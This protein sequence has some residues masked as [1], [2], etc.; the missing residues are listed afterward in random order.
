MQEIF[1][2]PKK[3][4]ILRRTWSL[5]KLESIIKLFTCTLQ[6]ACALRKPS[7]E[8]RIKSENMFEYPFDSYEEYI[9]NFANQLM[10]PF[11][12][13]FG[14]LYAASLLGSRALE[15]D[16]LSQAVYDLEEQ[17]L[18]RSLYQDDVAKHAESEA[19]KIV[20]YLRCKSKIT[21]CKRKLRLN[22]V[23]MCTLEVIGMANKWRRN[24]LNCEWNKSYRLCFIDEIKAQ[25]ETIN[26]WEVSIKKMCQE[27]ATLLES[28]KKVEKSNK[29]S[30]LGFAESLNRTYIREKISEL[31]K[32]AVENYNEILAYETVFAKLN[33]KFTQNYSDPLIECQCGELELNEYE[34]V[35]YTLVYFICLEF[36]EISIF[37]QRNISYWSILIHQ[38]LIETS[39]WN[40]RKGSVLCLTS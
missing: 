11:I 14:I 2:N 27:L 13:Y 29:S 18:E 24:E 9:T 23:K 40:V 28:V 34:K 7:Q 20:D 15:N 17:A 12:N 5:R 21:V 3:R 16:S 6:I 19:C 4:E 35:S 38:I 30:N 31:V 10:K 8:D 25:L 32:I 36:L 1:T 26:A 37:T 22:K 39:E 33:A